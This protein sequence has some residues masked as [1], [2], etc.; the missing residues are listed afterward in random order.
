MSSLDSTRLRGLLDYDPDTGVFTW[1]L[2]VSRNVRVG[3]VAG[4]IT[5][6]GYRVIR[7]SGRG[8]PAHRLAWLY[9]TDTLPMFQLDHINGVKDDNRISNLREVTAAQNT[10][11]RVRPQGANPYLG[12]YWYAQRRKWRA[13]I[14]VGGRAKHL[15]L[16]TTPEEARAVYLAAKA[17]LHSHFNPE[18]TT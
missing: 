10:Q 3:G 2:A 17:E 7:I 12:V 8:Y 18:R 4:N 11:N 14:V 16:F 6:S 9:T 1:R 15:G 13:L 5:A